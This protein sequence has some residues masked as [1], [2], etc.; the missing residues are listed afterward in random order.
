MLRCHNSGSTFVVVW[1]R[2]ADLREVYVCPQHESE[3]ESGAYWDLCGDHVVMNQDIA[4]ALERWWL[5]PSMG[6]EGFTLVL[7]TA[8]GTD[9]VDIFLTPAVAKSLALF[10]YPSSGLPL[11]PE[12]METLLK[13][14]ADDAD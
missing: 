8:G 7:E 12:L 9:P 2:G 1:H 10:L 6:T 4:P 14:E 5:R 13:E 11:P 3:I